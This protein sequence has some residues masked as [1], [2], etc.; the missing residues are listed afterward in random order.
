MMRKLRLMVSSWPLAKCHPVPDTLRAPAC[1]DGLQLLL[2]LSE[3]P[4]WPV[5]V[6]P[7]QVRDILFM[8]GCLEVPA[9]MEQEAPLGLLLALSSVPIVVPGEMVRL[10][11]GREWI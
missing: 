4:V 1:P 8:V 9:G 11:I 5:W 7:A 3:Q 2:A 6:P 10:R